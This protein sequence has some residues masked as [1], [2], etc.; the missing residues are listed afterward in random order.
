MVTYIDE[1][2]KESHNTA[3]GLS[4]FISLA[5]STLKDPLPR[6]EYILKLHG[7][8]IAEADQLEDLDLISEILEVREELENATASKVKE[9]T[10]NNHGT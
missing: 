3:A 8:E 9:I 6:A 7:I 2:S 4:H 5:Y 10:D 1:P